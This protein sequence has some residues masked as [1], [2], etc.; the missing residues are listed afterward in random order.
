MFILLLIK[1]LLSKEESDKH[2]YKKNLVVSL[3]IKMLY[4]FD[5]KGILMMKKMI[6]CFW[7]EG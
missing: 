7:L 1:M 3:V 4:V 2:A 6:E 5:I